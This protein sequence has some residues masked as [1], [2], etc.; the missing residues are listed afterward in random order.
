MWLSFASFSCLYFCCIS[1][2]GFSPQSCPFYLYTWACSDDDD[3]DYDDISMH[4]GISW[5]FFSFIVRFQASSYVLLAV[6]VALTWTD[7]NICTDDGKCGVGVA[8]MVAVV[9]LENGASSFI[10]NNNSNNIKRNR[11]EICI[12]FYHHYC[13]VSI[14]LVFSWSLPKIHSFSYSVTL[15]NLCRRFIAL[16]LAQR[17]H[18]F[19]HA[20]CIM[21]K[22]IILKWLS[23][24]VWVYFSWCAHANNNR[25]LLQFE[26]AVNEIVR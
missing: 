7:Q 11:W 14:F 20:V 19:Q 17:I 1:C 5:V 16:A 9:H 25:I 23:L 21:Y 13:F 8:V 12:I 15:H 22:D 2:F 6:D 26:I 10:H 3:D 18:I 24:Y 4:L